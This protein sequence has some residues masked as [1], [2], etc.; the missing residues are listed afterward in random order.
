MLPIADTLAGAQ[1]FTSWN[2][3]ADSGSCTISQTQAGFTLDARLQL[4]A[5]GNLTGE[6]TSQI[7]FTT[8]VVSWV[9]ISTDLT[10]LVGEADLNFVVTAILSSGETV[11]LTEFRIDLE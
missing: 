8:A 9:K 11:T 10:G 5:N 2:K 3:I 6:F 7:D 4:S 1:T